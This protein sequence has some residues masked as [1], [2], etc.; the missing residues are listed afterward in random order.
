M[1]I[2]NNADRT[3]WKAYGFWAFWVGVAFFSIYPTCNW[4]TSLRSEPLALYIEPELNIPFV[5]E[6]VWVYLSMYILFIAPPFFLDVTRLRRLGKQ[7]VLGTIISGAIFITFPSSL[8][9]GR[10]VPEAPLYRSLFSSLYSVDL[11]HNMA[12]SLH[13]VF[14]SIILLL[15]VESSKSS[16]AKFFWWSWLILICASTLFVHQHHTIDVITGL[17]L[18]FICRYW[19]NKG[20]IHA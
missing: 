11:P 2:L 7:L 10:V 3:I 17:A 15:L 13:V 20:E 12:P 16:V 14:S 5:P 19:V 1:M 9:F 8:G 18:A 4:L 6:F